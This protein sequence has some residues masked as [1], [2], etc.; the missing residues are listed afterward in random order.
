MTAA[1][2]DAWLALL[3]S[4]CAQA[5]VLWL[6]II[7][8]QA[9]SDSPLLPSVLAVEPP[10]PWHSL[11]AGLPEAGAEDLAPLLIRV[12]LANPLQRQWLMGLLHNVKVQSQVLV[13]ASHWPFPVLA[14]YLG[15]CLEA[16]NGG[17]LGLLRYYDPRLFPLLFSHVLEPDQQQLLL[18][19]AVFWSWLDRD[20]QPQR[21][22]GAH[23]TP[24][25]VDDCC[26]LELS[27]SQVDTLGCASDAAAVLKL[28]HQENPER[29]SAQQRFQACYLA[30]IEAT[31][32]GLMGDPE[33]ETFVLA[34]LQGAGLSIFQ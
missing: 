9:G 31:E 30:M 2:L 19:P 25:D 28:V 7:V 21:L 6:D 10:L 14:D 15:R 27:D 4:S 8:D 12:D 23:A 3:D 32:V 34:K 16:R 29:W 17:C 13:L 11:F 24:Q 33:R 5:R 22:A 1:Q 18:R 20:D 26:P